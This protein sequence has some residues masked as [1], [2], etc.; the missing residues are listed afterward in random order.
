MRALFLKAIDNMSARDKWLVNYAAKWLRLIL[1]IILYT[2]IVA[3]G[4]YAKAERNFEDWKV[5]YAE[6]FVQHMEA[7]ETNM[8]QVVDQE[9]MNRIEMMQEYWRHKK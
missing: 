2:L 4:A 7:V 5:E 1:A 6:G 8:P 9:Q 3:R